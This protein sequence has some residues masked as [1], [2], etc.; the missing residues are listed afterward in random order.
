MCLLLG[1]GLYLLGL[2]FDP[3]DGDATSFRN[4]GKLYQ[5]KHHYIP[6]DPKILIL[7]LQ[8]VKAVTMKST[9][10]RDVTC[11]PVVLVASLTYISP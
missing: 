7:G 4:A 2:F 6:E 8:V 9:V 3:D 5:I 1:R 10:F 11:S